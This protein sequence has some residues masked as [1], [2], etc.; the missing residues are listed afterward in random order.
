MISPTGRRGFTLIEVL[1]AL[2]IVATVLGGALALVR[3][4]IGNHEYLERRLFAEWV[5][6][7][8]LNAY[9]LE[10]QRFDRRHRSGEETVLARPFSWTLDVAETDRDP[11]QPA[12]LE[13]TVAVTDAASAGAALARRRLV[14][15][16][17]PDARP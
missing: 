9:R 10:P 4:A 3:G 14:L 8:T 5:A 12:L 16:G 13:V 11:P 7:N 6:D 15:P 17:N 2:A 1:I